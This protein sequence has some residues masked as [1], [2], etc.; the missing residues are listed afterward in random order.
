M[1]KSLLSLLLLISFNL[2]AANYNGEIMK[3]KQPDGTS[4]D[5][6]L[7]GSEYYMRSEGLDNYSLI[8]DEQS[9]WICYAKLSEDG[10]TLVSTGIVYRG[11]QNDPS[12]LRSN[13]NLPFHLQIDIKSRQKIIKTNQQLLGDGNKNKNRLTGPG[14]GNNIVAGTPIN[15]VAG[16]ILGLCIVVDFADEQGILPMS[17]YDAF[18]N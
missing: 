14:Q 17:E 16:S 8:R 7:F 11:Q 12:S 6:K 13:L 18:C 10:T 3:F 1:N 4:V 9:K 2:S 15:P 5:V